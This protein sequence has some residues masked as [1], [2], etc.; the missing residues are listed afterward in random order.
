MDDFN[1][2]DAFR[3]FDVDGEGSITSKQIQDGLN[4][5]LGCYLTI[6]D[7]HHFMKVFDKD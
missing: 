7:I 5:F 1:L 4:Q 2:I 3:I 6:A